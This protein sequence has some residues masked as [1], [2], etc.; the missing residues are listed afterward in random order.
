MELGFV[1]GTLT[2]CME[3]WI[4]LY[5]TTKLGRDPWFCL[6]NGLPQT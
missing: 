1:Y 5:G 6:V 4:F 3:L 2:F